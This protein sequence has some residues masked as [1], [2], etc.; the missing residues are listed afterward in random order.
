MKKLYKELA[1]VLIIFLAAVSFIEWRLKDI[2]APIDTI[3]ALP[4]K[5][6]SATILIVGN[7]HTGALEETSD[8]AFIKSSVN[9]SLANLELNDRLKVIAYSL[10]KSNIKTLILG[11]DVDQIG[12]VYSSSAYDLQLKRYG[13]ELNDN[14]IGNR[15]LAQL[16]S[17]RLHL[18]ISDLI[19]NLAKGKQ[20]G[21]EKMNF[22]P[23][24]NKERND[25]EACE[26]RAQEHSLYMYKASNSKRN[27]EIVQEIINICKEKNVALYLLQTPK[28]ECYSTTYNNAA[29]KEATL[30]VDSIA[31]RN[32]VSFLNYF[33]NPAFTDTDFADYDHLGKAGSDKLIGMIKKDL[34]N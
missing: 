17:F 25:K 16:N 8:S 21:I 18:G 19:K 12:H 28:P 30:Q 1:I 4:A 13:F 5:N 9:L 33:N 32:H 14:T 31:Q 20:S 23:F 29:M 11:M 6:P 2:N 15:V 34:K 27:L 22:I 24:S 7:S 10:R 3:L 26:K